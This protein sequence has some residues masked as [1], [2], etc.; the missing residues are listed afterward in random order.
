MSP[1]GG[2]GALT[3]EKTPWASWG[4]PAAAVLSLK[5]GGTKT[6]TATTTP[7]SPLP[8]RKLSFAFMGQPSN[9]RDEWWTLLNLS[10]IQQPAERLPLPSERKS[11]GPG[12]PCGGP[13][14]SCS[15][16]RGTACRAPTEIS[17][18]DRPH[19]IPQSYLNER[20]QRK[21]DQ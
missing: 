20:W 9:E 17:E 8:I 21:P 18:Q 13:G 1:A 19:H 14:P 16:G 4:G 2:V 10:I 3:M 7:A 6:S 5:A 15:P 11:K 12:P